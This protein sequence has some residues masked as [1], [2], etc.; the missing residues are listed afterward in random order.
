MKLYLN[1]DRDVPDKGLKAYDSI[2]LH[3]LDISKKSIGGTHLVI[4]GLSCRPNILPIGNIGVLSNKLY[5][6]TF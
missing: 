2:L 6:I 4:G 1:I 3:F 5:M